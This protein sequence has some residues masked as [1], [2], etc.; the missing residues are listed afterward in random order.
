MPFDSVLKGSS[1]TE[2]LGKGPKHSRSL[3]YHER[4]DPAPPPPGNPLV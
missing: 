4:L 2:I 3:G 1:S